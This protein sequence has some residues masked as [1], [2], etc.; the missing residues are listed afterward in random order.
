MGLALPSHLVRRALLLHPFHSSGSR[1]MLQWSWY[2]RLLKEPF[3]MEWTIPQHEEIDLN[4]E[5]N[6]YANA[7][8]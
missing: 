6:S 3:F 1:V 2:I 7:E 5:V 8:L 4:C